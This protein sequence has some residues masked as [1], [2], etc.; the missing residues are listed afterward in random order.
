[1]AYPGKTP[2]FL[3]LREPGGERIFIETHE[4]YRVSPSSEFQ[5]AITERFGQ[6]TFHVKVDTSLP[7]REKRKWEKKASSDNG[8]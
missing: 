6:D 3:C 5:R 7:E 4:R 1:V 2:V 8:E